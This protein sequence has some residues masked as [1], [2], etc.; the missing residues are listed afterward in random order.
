MRYTIMNVNRKIIKK[1]PLAQ[2]DDDDYVKADKAQLLSLVWEIT[3][4]TWSFMKVQDAE[5]RLQRNVA[6]LAGRKS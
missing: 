5:Q 4:E 6:V 1:L 2:E 3:E